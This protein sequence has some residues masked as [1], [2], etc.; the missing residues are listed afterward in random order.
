MT[1]FFAY[2]SYWCRILTP[3]PLFLALGGGGVIVEFWPPFSV[4]ATDVEFWGHRVRPSLPARDELPPRGCASNTQRMLHTQTV[5]AMMKSTSSWWHSVVLYAHNNN[6]FTHAWINLPNNM[7]SPRGLT[8]AEF[9]WTMIIIGP[10]GP[11]GPRSQPACYRTMQGWPSR[12]QRTVSQPT[13]PS[14]GRD[15]H[16]HKLFMYRHWLKPKPKLCGN[17][18][19]LTWLKNIISKK[20]ADYFKRL[21]NILRV[22]KSN[23]CKD[24]WKSWT[25]IP[26]P[27][28]PTWIIA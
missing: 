17:V 13:W 8:E 22:L 24:Y 28:C 1:P 15:I 25:G 6:H 27:K 19:Q 3:P 10:K 23:N 21:H 16:S 12:C 26:V 20:I 11:K 4:S 5:A 2:F 9:M 7:L 14:V 18:Q